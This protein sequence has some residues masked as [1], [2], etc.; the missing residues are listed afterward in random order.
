MCHGT[1]A[2]YGVKGGRA[3]TLSSRDV[4]DDDG[5]GTHSSADEGIV[6]V[7]ELGLDEG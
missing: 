7:R 2:E 5:D 1:C 4:A 6:D 3:C